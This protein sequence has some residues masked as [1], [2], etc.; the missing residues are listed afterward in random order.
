[1]AVEVR[2][3]SGD[4]DL[5]TA[6]A[7]DLSSFGYPPETSPEAGL[8]PWHRATTNYLA[9]D[10]GEPAGTCRVHDL[11]L[12]VPGGNSVGVSGIGDVGVPAGH[13]RRGVLRSMVTTVLEDGA[14]RGHAAAALY[15]SEATI[16]GRFGFGPATRSKKVR[17]ETARA[18]LRPEVVSSPGL[19]RVVAPEH[20]AAYLKPVYERARIRRAGEVARSDLL[21]DR[22]LQPRPLEST[23]NRMCLSHVDDGGACD[24]YALYTITPEWGPQGPMHSLEVQ[25]LVA[26][27]DAAELS[28]WDALF[29]LDLIRTV[30]AWVPA[31]SL[32]FDALV[33]RWA[34]AT[35]GEHDTLW[36]RVLDVRAA[37]AARRYRVPGRLVIG[38]I[39]VVPGSPADTVDTF[40][41][42]SAADGSVR[43]LESDAEPDIALGIAELG[44]V[45][46]GSG[47]LAALGAV[48][49]V[50]EFNAGSLGLADAMFGWS[51]S[52]WI[53]QQ[54]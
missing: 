49:R 36:V 9:N 20:R 3:V 39:A 40:E 14:R 22:E 15:A 51:P 52:P 13:T 4:D 8:E 2:E 1:M 38:V 17:I 31:D 37:L 26:A 12:T 48:G 50:E 47:S 21:W 41:L 29:S 34:P 25:E 11:E 42:S 44:S 32:L 18:A 46:L 33:D 30:N 19:V 7:I 16:Y 53:T 27:T 35:V 24:A 28:M 10:D 5:R 23:E 45:W 54:F 43:V 6:R